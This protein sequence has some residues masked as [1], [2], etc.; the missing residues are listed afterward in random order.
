MQ[1]LAIFQ[2]IYEGRC[3]CNSQL[4]NG[5]SCQGQHQA[6]LKAG[7]LGNSLWITLSGRDGYKW[8]SVVE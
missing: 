7:H 3:Y 1:I 6:A 8:S 2:N 5:N 4:L